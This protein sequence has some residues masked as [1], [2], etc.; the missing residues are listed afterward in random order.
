[1]VSRKKKAKGKARTKVAKAANQQDEK[2]RVVAG[3]QQEEPLE[4]Q[5]QQLQ[6]NGRDDDED[7]FLEE[8]IKLAAAEEKNAL[9]EAQE[10]R[11]QLSDFLM[12]RHGVLPFSEEQICNKF[13]DAYYKEFCACMKRDD[14]LARCFMKA[15]E[16]ASSKC[17]GVWG[18]L[19]K[20]EW[21]VSQFLSHGTNCILNENNDIARFYAVI[22]CNFEQTI[23]PKSKDFS[24]LFEMKDA[25]LHTLISFF[26]KRVPCNCLDAKY[27][28]V[29]SMPK[30]GICA[31]FHCPLP[32]R[33]SKRKGMV[34]CTLCRQ[35]SYCSRECQVADWPIHKEIC[36]DLAN[37]L[38]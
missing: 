31:H 37:L 33:K 4:K 32:D 6:I 10:Q 18:D 9:D 8:A 26:R 38:L 21:A 20:M 7:A 23:G 24:K 35:A 25:D 11:P 29:K 28:E 36:T 12:C 22:A 14:S 27:K 16:D 2:G 15:R 3:H 5:L 13:V 17:P 19:M 30:M 1:M 34:Y